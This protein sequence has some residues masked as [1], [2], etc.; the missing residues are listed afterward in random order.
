MDSNINIVND[1]LYPLDFHNSLGT[2]LSLDG[3]P[4]STISNKVQDNNNLPKSNNPLS[5]HNLTFIENGIVYNEYPI[6]VIRRIVS[7]ISNP[8]DLY[9]CSLLN[10]AWAHCASFRLYSNVDHPLALRNV[11]FFQRYKNFVSQATIDGSRIV[12]AQTDNTAD[13]FVNNQNV[14]SSP[15]DPAFKDPPSTAFSFTSTS[16]TGESSKTPENVNIANNT[17]SY[18]LSNSHSYR[19][20]SNYTYG[21]FPHSPISTM[22]NISNANDDLN[23]NNQSPG[24][25]NI[26]PAQTNSIN[27]SAH[28]FTRDEIGPANISIDNSNFS[29]SASANNIEDRDRVVTRSVSPVRTTFSP[30]TATEWTSLLSSPNLKSLALKNLSGD[31]PNL[32]TYPD[33]NI[34]ELII[35]SWR[36]APYYPVNIEQIH[37]S[38]Q[39]GIFDIVAEPIISEA[40]LTESQLIDQ[41][42][43][44]KYFI[45]KCPKLTKLSLVGHLEFSLLDYLFNEVDESEYLR[46]LSKSENS[47]DYYYDFYK[48]LTACQKNKDKDDAGENEK[49]STFSP[50]KHG[51]SDSLSS[52]NT[53]KHKK[54][55]RRAVSQKMMRSLY[56]LSREVSNMSLDELIENPDKDTLNG[57]NRTTSMSNISSYLSIPRNR[58][59]CNPLV[60]ITS[61]SL[62]SLKKEIFEPTESISKQTLDLI[63][64]FTNIRKFTI[65]GC[66]LPFR[67]DFE[68]AFTGKLEVFIVTHCTSISFLP[69][70]LK[71]LVLYN[72]HMSQVAFNRE[73][74][75]ETGQSFL[76]DLELSFSQLILP[77]RLPTSLKSITLY[78]CPNIDKIYQVFTLPLLRVINTRFCRGLDITSMEGDENYNKNSQ[79]ADIDNINNANNSSESIDRGRDAGSND[80]GEI[81]DVPT[82]EEDENGKVPNKIVLTLKSIQNRR[83]RAKTN[84]KSST[85]A[86]NKMD[87]DSS[88]VDEYPKVLEDGGVLTESEIVIEKYGFQGTWIIESCNIGSASTTSLF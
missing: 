38:N 40:N 10:S 45:A 47:N 28:M 29:G 34:K 69:K 13:W 17:T 49:F 64:Q 33:I 66:K 32:E 36:V 55:I 51:S 87:N 31:I 24:H 37:N 3:S 22:S 53:N 60:Q 80:F 4:I 46:M 42:D 18:P 72:T 50:F 81:K 2:P 88:I 57:T 43:S 11:A 85:S 27:K 79:N 82:F 44:I 62:G 63:S 74:N 52:L 16:S 9:N 67:Y 25:F 61:L 59:L 19:N 8:K 39:T 15:R 78:E 75:P 12:A 35:D 71:K 68:S 56:S 1:A 6:D 21:D 83:I 58:Y 23:T 73:M 20:D 76:R 48:S 14:C 86:V 70:E 26:S 41:S 7:Y 30:F 84:E 65:V 77:E 5:N 54:G